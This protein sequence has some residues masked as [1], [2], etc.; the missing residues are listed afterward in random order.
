MGRSVSYPSGATVAYFAAEP[1]ED[2]CITCSNVASDCTCAEEDRD[3]IEGE[4]NF[5]SLREWAMDA[6]QSLFPSMWP[7]DREW[8]GRED[9]VL[10]RNYLADFGWSEYCGLIAFWL[11]PREGL[12]GNL[13]AFADRWIASVEGKFSKTFANLTRLGTFSNGEGV[14]QRI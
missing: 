8:R 3:M 12:E 10:M 5:D 1:D 9:R 11:V 6:A 13:E 4:V 7:E 2:F 14:F